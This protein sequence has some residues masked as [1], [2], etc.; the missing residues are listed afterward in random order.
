MA[1]YL[2]MTS[3]VATATAG[4]MVDLLFRI[5]GLVPNAR[6]AFVA[7]AHLTLNY[8]SVLNIIFLV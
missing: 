5:L 1:L 8:T 7:E 3:Y 6:H 4:L 2:F